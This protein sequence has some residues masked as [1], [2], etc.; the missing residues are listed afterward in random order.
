MHKSNIIV[1]ILVGSLSFL[2]SATSQKIVTVH[3]APGV[4]PV[5]GAL[6]YVQ[7]H[8]AQRVGLIKLLN[9][10]QAFNL[11]VVT[12]KSQRYLIVSHKQNLLKEVFTQP[13]TTPG[14]MLI[15]VPAIHNG[16]QPS[17]TLD[18]EQLEALKGE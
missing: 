7:S 10:E 2:L 12:S 14:V 15:P 18:A 11:P 5:Y 17:I 3:A 6:Y 13:F 4:Q 1:H 16:Q 8:S 9:R